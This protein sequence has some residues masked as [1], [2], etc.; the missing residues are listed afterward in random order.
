MGLRRTI[1]RPRINQGKVEY[2]KN[3]YRKKSGT[4]VPDLPAD[5]YQ[6]SQPIKTDQLPDADNAQQLRFSQK[7]L[8][9]SYH[10]T[11]NK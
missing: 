9:E 8:M 1:Y 4:R 7:Y 3:P 11:N 6:F 10:K 2:I 5:G